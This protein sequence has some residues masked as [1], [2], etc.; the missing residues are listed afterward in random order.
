M[1][2]AQ[3]LAAV[4][5]LIAE[6]R[7]KKKN[8]IKAKIK[9]KVKLKVQKEIEKIQE[10]CNLTLEKIKLIRSEIDS[11]NPRMTPLQPHTKTKWVQDL[12]N[13]VSSYYI[14]FESIKK[15]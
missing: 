12:D 15:E 10:S 2:E 14:P 7:A 8:K 11:F 4:G 6:K 13:I 3:R 1:K 9:A 5:G